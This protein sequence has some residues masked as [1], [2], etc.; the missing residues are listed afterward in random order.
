MFFVTILV[1]NSM[2]RSQSHTSRKSPLPLRRAKQILRQRRK[3]SPDYRRAQE[4]VKRHNRLVAKSRT[5]PGVLQVPVGKKSTNFLS[6][7]L[8]R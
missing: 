4:T 3:S 1:G 5:H 6:Y 7:T 2:R 8:S